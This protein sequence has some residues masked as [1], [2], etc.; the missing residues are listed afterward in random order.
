MHVPW[1][2]RTNFSSRYIVELAGGTLLGLD[3]MRSAVTDS[4]V[5]SRPAT[6]TWP[7]SR[8]ARASMP[9]P[10]MGDSGSSSGTAWR[11]MFEPIRARLA[12]SCSRNGMSAVATDTTCLGLTSMYSI[13]CGRA[14]GNG[15]R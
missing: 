12:S 1:L 2:E 13:C 9:V 6:T 3:G 7:E 5:P 14:S 11:C 10:T 15:S 8:A 4:T